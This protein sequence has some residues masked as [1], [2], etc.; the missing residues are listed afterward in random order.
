M[1]ENN[2]S[3]M[4]LHLALP[5]S[6]VVLFFINAALPVTVLGCANR[7]WV[8]LGLAGITVLAAFYTVIQALRISR[9]DRGKSFWWIISTIILVIPSIAL[10]F[11]A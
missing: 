4:M 5:L 10:L 6:L 7:G 9:T 8:A 2:R 11:L 1:Y 3:R